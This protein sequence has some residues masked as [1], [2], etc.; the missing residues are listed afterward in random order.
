[1]Q[2]HGILTEKTW[3]TSTARRTIAIHDKRIIAS[4]SDIGRAVSLPELFIEAAPLHGRTAKAGDN[5]TA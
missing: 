4:R 2:P 3:R 1:M 5:I